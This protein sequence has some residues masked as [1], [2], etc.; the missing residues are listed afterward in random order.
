MN[1]GP[2]R[3]APHTT[4]ENAEEMIAAAEAFLMDGKLDVSE[5]LCRQ[6]LD[7]DRENADAIAV[8]GRLAYRTGDREQARRMLIKSAEMAPHKANHHFWLGDIHHS[9]G[10]IEA[11]VASYYR[12]LDRDPDFYG[13]LV[14]LGNSLLNLQKY[15]AA[16][17][18][19]RRA[20][21]LVPESAE[22]YSN[23]GQACL[24]Q[25]RLA[26]AHRALTTSVDL[27]PKRPD[28][29]NN[30]GVL[31][32]LIGDVDGA[33]RSFQTALETGSQASLAE[34]NLKI[35]V[36]NAPSWDTQA[37]FN[38]HVELAKRHNK[39]CDQRKNPAH[40]VYSTDRKLRIG[41][42]SS[43][44][45]DHPVGN[46]VLPLLRHHDRRNVEV[47]LYANVE[48]PDQ[49]TALFQDIADHWRDTSS[50]S[51]A[52]LARQISEDGIDIAVYLAG[53]FNLNRVETAAFRPAPVQVSFHDCATTG[54]D[55]IDYWLT[56][57]LLHPPETDEQFT[58]RLYRLPVF[59]Q[60]EKPDHA[61]QV[62][63]PPCLKNGYVTFGSFNKPEKLS[64]ETVAL[65]AEILR[66][67]EHSK[68]MLKHRNLFA[69]E[70][71]KTI[72]RDRFFQEGIEKDRLLLMAGD[73]VR[74][75]H[76]ALY[77]QI[78][79]ALDPFPFNGATTTFEALLMGVPVITLKGR[80]FVD[81]VG[82]TLLQQC[83]LTE[84][85]AEDK[86]AYVDKAVRLASDP[87]QVAAW[88]E[89]IRL[90]LLD[91]ALFKGQTYA[92]SVEA[93]YRDMW[94]RKCAEFT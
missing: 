59:Y 47:T 8:L 72:W 18:V 45:H 85:I 24:K 84:F 92:K 22:A 56:D 86:G 17:D 82:A 78:D 89:K 46:N 16:E 66:Q 62:S 26:E 11:A 33:I 12:A 64:S 30:Y 67:T 80:H 32:Q 48:A 42:I 15:S 43:D 29:L 6:V 75:E 41:Y 39:L 79:I 73:H 40:R 54:L 65:W 91:S 55:A 36:L 21:D 52:K 69:D 76:L 20:I 14:N 51:N 49:K 71:I 19:S 5:T 10:N 38:L 25:G 94:H 74:T 28:L 81:R 53:R 63:V 35:A 90:H 58:E 31:Q 44:F 23:L 60:F 37:L 3:S 61:P 88:R 4:Y 87:S 93:A 13:V 57:G 2:A 68:L 77:R 9:F 1:M 7:E 34:R 70:E 83:A 50:Q 27:A